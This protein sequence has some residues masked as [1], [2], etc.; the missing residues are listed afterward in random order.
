MMYK[1]DFFEIQEQTEV[2]RFSKNMHFSNFDFLIDWIYEFLKTSNVWKNKNMIVRIK[3]I[4]T[5]QQTTIYYY[6]EQ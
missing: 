5:P 6:A 1:I 2:Y 4:P 3:T